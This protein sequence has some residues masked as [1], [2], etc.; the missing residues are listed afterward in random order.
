M[1]RA[2]VSAPPAGG[3]GTMTRTG[4]VGQA[5]CASARPTSDAAA[6]AANSVRRVRAVPGMAR[7]ASFDG[8]L[9][10]DR[11]CER[12]LR[13]VC[14]PAVFLAAA[15]LDAAAE[16][17]VGE[18]AFRLDPAGVAAIAAPGRE[19]LDRLIKAAAGGID[20]GPAVAR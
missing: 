20:P 9:A 5:T 15:V 11:G 1:M 7:S 13:L 14:V 18:E 2:V 4:G 6:I 10:P 8:N 16:F 12:P 19:L 3:Y 17:Q